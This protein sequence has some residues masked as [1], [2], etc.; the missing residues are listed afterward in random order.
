MPEIDDGSPHFSGESLLEHDSGG[1]VQ[2]GQLVAMDSQPHQEEGVIDLTD[3]L[4]RP[5]PNWIARTRIA[6]PSGVEMHASHQQKILDDLFDSRIACLYTLDPARFDIKYGLY[7]N[8]R[9]DAETASSEVDT[10]LLSQVAIDGAFIES[11]IVTASSNKELF[12]PKE[13]AP[14]AQVLYFPGA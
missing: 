13:L 1:D 10:W 3:R 8:D 12:E 11:A 5:Y 7:E 9:N 14:G 4:A 6:L 2:E